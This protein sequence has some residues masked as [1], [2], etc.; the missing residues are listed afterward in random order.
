MIRFGKKKESETI[1]KGTDKMVSLIKAFDVLNYTPVDYTYTHEYSGFLASAEETFLKVIQE[2]SIDDLNCDM[3]DSYV[4]SAIDKMKS[5]AKMQFT[6]HIAQTSHYQG[7][8]DGEMIRAKGHRDN[9]M[10]DLVSDEEKLAEYKS[11]KQ[12]LNIH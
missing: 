8:I 4:Q 11:I 3:F 12:E 7:I 9:L 2:T 6:Y 10:A 1:G 5:S